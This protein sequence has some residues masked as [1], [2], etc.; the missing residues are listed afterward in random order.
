MMKAPFE[1]FQVISQE[2]DGAFLVQVRPSEDSDGNHS[3]RRKFIED[4]IREA[5]AAP[6]SPPQV[7]AEACELYGLGCTCGADL[8]SR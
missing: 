2:D 4:A 8:F 6:D 5:L 7:H 3:E 1:T